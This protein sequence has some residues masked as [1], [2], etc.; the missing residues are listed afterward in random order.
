MPTKAPT[1]G[2]GVRRLFG[3]GVGMRGGRTYA[4]H[5]AGSVM[6]PECCVRAGCRG[7]GIWRLT[8]RIGFEDALQSNRIYD[9]ASSRTEDRV[10]QKYVL[11]WDSRLSS[12]QAEAHE[13]AEGEFGLNVH[14][15][16]L[17]HIDCY[18]HTQ[19]IR[20]AIETLGRG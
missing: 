10:R 11:P 6:P 5:I 8:C 18:S 16:S 15:Q 4:A 1:L 17:D 7:G 12:Q 13:A 20:K 19:E 14:L 9:D 3:G 2:R